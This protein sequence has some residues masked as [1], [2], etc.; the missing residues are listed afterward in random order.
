MTI[1]QYPIWFDKDFCETEIRIHR[2]QRYWFPPVIDI[3][4]PSKIYKIDLKLTHKKK[5]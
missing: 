5:A 4:Y 2:G 3:Y 1:Y